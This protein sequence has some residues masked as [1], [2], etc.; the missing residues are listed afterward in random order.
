[1]TG[2]CLLDVR[3]VGCVRH[4]HQSAKPQAVVVKVDTAMSR[5]VERI[6]VDDGAGPHHIELHKIEQAWFRRRDS[7]RCHLCIAACAC[8]GFAGSAPVHR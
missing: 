4:A 5:A 6:D 7:L 8:D 2:Y 3:M 1:M